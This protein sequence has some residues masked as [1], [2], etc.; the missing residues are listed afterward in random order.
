MARTGSSGPPE[1]DGQGGA[2]AAARSFSGTA[3]SDEGN[4]PVDAGTSP[5]SPPASGTAASAPPPSASVAAAAARPSGSTAD[6]T[7]SRKNGVHPVTQLRVRTCA[8][9]YPSSCREIM[10]G[11]AAIGDAEMCDYLYLPANPPKVKT[12]LQKHCAQYLEN[13]LHH[14][15]GQDSTDVKEQTKSGMDRRVAFHHFDPRVRECIR[16]D[17]K[18]GKQ[19]IDRYRVPDEIGRDI[20]TNRDKCVVPGTDASAGKTYFASPTV[21]M[22]DARFALRTAE[23]SHER[24]C[25]A[26]GLSPAPSALPPGT[27]G[28]QTRTPEERELDRMTR[29][30]R[31]NPEAAAIRIRDLEKQVEALKKALKKQKKEYDERVAKLE[32]QMAVQRE[33]LTEKLIHSGLNRQSLV[34]ESYHTDK[35]WVAKFLFG[36]PWKEHVARGDAL[37]GGGF[38][39]D[40]DCNVTG[41]GNITPFE[42]YCMCCMIVWQAFLNPTVAAIY[43]RDPSSVSRYMTEWMPLLGEAGSDL[44]EL[45]LNMNHNYFDI[46]FCK[47]DGMAYIENGVLHNLKLND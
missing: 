6:A 3:D 37:F 1:A 4:A 24:R 7:R 12:P 46:G 35:P 41:T 14:L 26:A 27:T 2:A 10:W 17:R 20:L 8:C 38:V 16:G 34:S 30:T 11:Y 18:K 15:Y 44:S 9:A 25:A 28:R 22:E 21:N 31:E 45:D 40:F 5:P 47:E 33:E 43:N 42:K 23:I 39:K 29:E 19:K 32:D 36:R 13:V